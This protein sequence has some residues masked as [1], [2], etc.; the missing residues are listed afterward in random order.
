MI[1]QQYCTP[2]DVKSTLIKYPINDLKKSNFRLIKSSCLLIILPTK[3]KY[4]EKAKEYP[5]FIPK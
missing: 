1:E 4:E 2:P 5:L 3:Y